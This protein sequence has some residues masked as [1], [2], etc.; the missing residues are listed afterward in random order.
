M[1][2]LFL[3]LLTVVQLKSGLSEEEGTS[4]IYVINLRLICI[5]AYT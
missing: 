2:R 3:L 4:R 1:I 5:H